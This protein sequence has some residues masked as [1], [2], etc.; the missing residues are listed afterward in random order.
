MLFGDRMVVFR[1]KG[2][3]QPVCEIVRDGPRRMQAPHI[4]T[5]RGIRSSISMQLDAAARTPCVA[6]AKSSAGG[7]LDITQAAYVGVP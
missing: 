5:E 6:Q 2:K 4:G 3:R 7:N 1:G